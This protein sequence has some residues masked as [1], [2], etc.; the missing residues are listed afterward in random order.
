MKN[1]NPEL[2]NEYRST[3]KALSLRCGHLQQIPETA[4]PQYLQTARTEAEKARREHNSVRDRL[5]ACLSTRQ[6]AA[7]A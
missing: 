6:R 2:W 1:K 3:W 5:A 7:G 4:D